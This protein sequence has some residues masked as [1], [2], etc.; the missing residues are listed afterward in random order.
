M[1]F[2]NVLIKSSESKTL[3]SED[4]GS[5]PSRTYCILHVLFESILNSTPLSSETRQA[6][7]DKFEER[8][9]PPLF[10]LL[11]TVLF[12]SSVIATLTYPVGV[13]KRSCV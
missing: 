13:R 3:A 12:L 8:Q 11:L 5:I 9:H 7:L 1:I 10:R 4:D 6:V 2:S